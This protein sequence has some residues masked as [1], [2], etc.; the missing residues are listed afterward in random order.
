M[1]K[2]CKGQQ[3]RR[4]AGQVLI[5]VAIV[6]VM[7]LG[8]AAISIDYAHVTVAKDELRRAA[9]AAAL[10]A[11][12]QLVH[13][14]FNGARTQ[15]VHFAAANTIGGK[16]VVLDPSDDVEFGQ[17]QDPG[18]NPSFVPGATPADSVRVTARCTSGSAN[19]PIPTFFAGVLGQSSVE[20]MQSSVASLPD[21]RVMFVLDRSGSMDDDTPPWRWGQPQPTPQPITNM[22]DAAVSFVSRLQ[23][24]R[25]K[26]GLVAY[27][28]TAS[29]KKSLTFDLASVN[30]AIRQL[31][32]D[33]WT[34]IGDGI[35]IG[36][37][38]LNADP[39]GYLC[40]KVIVLLSDGNANRPYNETYARQ[41]AL[42]K[43]QLCTASGVKVFT[44]SLGTQADQA[45]MQQIAQM[46]DGAHFHAP[47]SD[48]L[49]A[50]FNAIFDRIP[51]RL[52]L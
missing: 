30:T 33:G 23:V 31:Y 25:D 16:N 32:A 6:M 8:F 2:Q 46:T 14:D 44:V 7:L 1:M 4:E 40:V 37:N 47:T 39:S 43:A 3:C 28:T 24:N 34:D 49:P 26:A 52:S 13:Q 15:A 41:Y 20:L 35:A 51:P 11:A 10:A 9:D 42:D 48:Q 36:L 12:S 18:D 29:L 17:M 5:L 22:L 38:Q 21:K 27:S 50:T 45:L 19:G